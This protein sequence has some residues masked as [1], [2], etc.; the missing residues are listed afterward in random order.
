[1]SASTAVDGY[2]DGTSMR[3]GRRMGRLTRNGFVVFRR[4]EC[5]RIR[6]QY[7]RA[8]R[9][10]NELVDEYLR[11]RLSY[12]TRASNR[13][14]PRSSG[15]AGWHFISGRWRRDVNLVPHEDATELVNLLV[16]HWCAIPE[17]AP[18]LAERIK[19]LRLVHVEHQENS[20]GPTKEG[21]R[22]T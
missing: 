6:S 17:L 14:I 13:R 5:Q 18:P 11:L 9:R 2:V 1:M 22:Q 7:G 12:T 20:I 19:R 16:G 10:R 15:Q 21:R 3:R 8:R 4:S